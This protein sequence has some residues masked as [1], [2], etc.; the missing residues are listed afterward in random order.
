M[1]V[2]ERGVLIWHTEV[3]DRGATG[4]RLLPLTAIIR[5][6]AVN[7]VAHFMHEVALSAS[8]FFTPLQAGTAVVAP[9]GASGRITI[10]TDHVVE[11]FFVHVALL[12]HI[13]VFG[14]LGG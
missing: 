4:Y 13:G 11:G 6:A 7:A 5:D 3:H 8:W 12:G 1:E 2:H 10:G 9:A 14:V